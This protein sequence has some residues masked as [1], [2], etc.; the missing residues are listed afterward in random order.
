[1]E[2]RRNPGY[3]SLNADRSE[4]AAENAR[5]RSL[6]S[7]SNIARP[8][9]LC[10]G[11]ILSLLQ[12]YVLFTTNTQGSAMPPP[13]AK[14]LYAFGVLDILVFLSLPT[15]VR[16]LMHFAPITLVADCRAVSFCSKSL[17]VSFQPGGEPESAPQ[18]VLGRL[19]P[20]RRKSDSIKSQT[21]GK[22]KAS[23]QCRAEHPD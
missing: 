21:N 22:Q 18:I 4:G 20:D 23:C 9:L 19:L 6:S 7:S 1:M 3:S 13:W 16:Y 8:L 10:V 5:R 11:R 17:R 2:A 14:F 12:S 15:S